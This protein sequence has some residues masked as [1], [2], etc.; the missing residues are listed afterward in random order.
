MIYAYHSETRTCLQVHTTGALSEGYV[1]LTEDE[2]SL[3]FIQTAPDGYVI[4]SDEN[5]YPCFIQVMT[6]QELY[7][8][9][10]NN[11]DATRRSLYLNVDALRNEAAMIRM[12]EGDDIKSAD[13][14]QQAIALYLKIRDENPWPEPPKEN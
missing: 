12:I 7:E 4:S 14:E 1:Q 10:L 11:V 6:P 8:E 13:Y 2:Y 9:K 3:Y 5:G